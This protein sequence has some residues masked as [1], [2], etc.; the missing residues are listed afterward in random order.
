MFLKDYWYVAAWDH[1]VA[2]GLL[3]RTLLGEPV[4]LFR[5]PDGTAVAL[6]DHC[7]HR[8]LPLSMGKPV[9]E[10]LQCG[11]HGLTFDRTGACVAVPG[12]SQVPPGASVRAYPLVE[13][14]HWLWIWM[15][16]PE[17]ADPA[18]IPDWWWLDHPDWDLVKGKHLHIQC[19]YELITDNLLDL[20]HL[21][22]VHLA[23]IGTGSITEF[24]ITTERED[25]LVRV[26]RWILDRAPPPLFKTVGGFEGTVDRWQIVETRAPC[27]TL[28]Y[29]GA[30]EAGAADPG[31]HGT[32]GEPAGGIHIRNVNAPTPETETSTFY[33]YGHAR[34]FGLGDAQVSK[35]MFEQFART[36]DEDVGILEA[37]QRSLDRDPDRP[38]VDIN[39]DAPGLAAR[40][41]VRERLDGARP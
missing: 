6:E 26:T 15:G 38:L 12:Q 41:M 24:P 32:R 28:I 18:L 5:T 34:D 17:R 16:D 35:T 29:A 4:V 20:S 22:Y 31:P 27:H 33:F 1:E 30:I 2:D 9:G 19:H 13:R 25:D 21:A 11:Y 40:R 23:T 37:Q 36:F 7:C 3:A 8:G 10:G 14:W 39:V